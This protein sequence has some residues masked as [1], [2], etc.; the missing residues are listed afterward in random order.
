MSWC[1]GAD[2]SIQSSVLNIRLTKPTPK[3]GSIK[4][5]DHYYATTHDWRI[6]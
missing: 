6:A 1:R 4:A 5:N 2:G 3:K